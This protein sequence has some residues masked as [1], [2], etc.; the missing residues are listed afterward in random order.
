MPIRVHE[1]E[2]IVGRL[3]VFDAARQR[4]RFGDAAIE[5]LAQRRQRICGDWGRPQRS[6]DNLRRLF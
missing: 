1:H 6:G 2:T 4:P 5:P 3:D